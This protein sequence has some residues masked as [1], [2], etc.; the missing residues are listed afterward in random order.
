ML[1]KAFLFDVDGTLVA[2]HELQANALCY[3]MEEIAKKYE[4]NFHSDSEL[5]NTLLRVLVG[6]SEETIVKK[7][8]ELFPHFRQW[9]V[10]L[11][12][13]AWKQ[14]Y[15]LAAESKNFKINESI[16]LLK[17]LKEIGYKVCLVSNSKR[18]DIE[19]YCKI[20]GLDEIIKEHLYIGYEDLSGHI[21]PSPFPYILAAKKL[22]V[23]PSNCIVFEDSEN[24][25]ISAKQAG[26]Y[27]V[28]LHRY[29]FPETL[30]YK[31]ADEV[32]HNLFQAKILARTMYA[33]ADL[34]LPFNNMVMRIVTMQDIDRG[35]REAIVK[36]TYEIYRQL[37]VGRSLDMWRDKLVDEK[38]TLTRVGLFYVDQNL[39]GYG[40]LKF[41]EVLYHNTK[42]TVSLGSVGL[43]EGFRGNSILLQYYQMEFRRFL[44][45]YFNQKNHMIDNFLSY[46]GYSLALRLF[47]S[48]YPSAVNPTMDDTLSEYTKFLANYVGYT[49]ANVENPWVYLSTSSVNMVPNTKERSLHKED[50]NCK[51]FVA[52]TDLIKGHGLLAISPV[53]I[54]NLRP[55]D[56]SP[57]QHKTSFCSYVSKS[58]ERN[59]LKTNQSIISEN[60]ASKSILD[61]KQKDTA[62]V[63][64]RRSRL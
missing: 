33:S 43:S 27:A 24:G 30:S 64:L 63:P 46:G 29:A 47:Y 58:E 51:F 6:S 38:D 13:N 1:D 42:H 55:M 20:L 19:H 48:V 57:L 62:N 26:M 50:P 25:I 32:V 3:A 23:L 53:T 2:S 52:Q 61:Q 39:V 4:L 17:T 12:S 7:V 16:Q 21:K 59:I 5:N 44:V 56:A 28:G 37:F 45:A 34:S 40:I 49:K 11:F 10:E 35:H 41:R 15:Q 8:L 18:K 60:A 31:G 54:S 14:Y 36:S 22:G 9:H